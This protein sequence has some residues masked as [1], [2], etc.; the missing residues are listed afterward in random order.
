MSKTVESSGS[1]ALDQSGDE[2]LGTR[3]DTFPFK[4]MVGT[5]DLIWIVLDSVRFDVAQRAHERGETP[6]LSSLIPRGW[7]C[8]H[9]PGTFTLPSHSAMFSGFLPTPK[10][11]TNGLVAWEYNSAQLFTNGAPNTALGD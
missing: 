7:E 6:N 2:V 9:S 8:R 3:Y 5:H 10:D 4:D 11:Q 1:E